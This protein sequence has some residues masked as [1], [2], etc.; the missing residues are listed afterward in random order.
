[1]ENSLVR[2]HVLNNT[3]GNYT[4]P[5]PYNQLENIPHVTALSIKRTR[6]SCLVPLLPSFRLLAVVV[7]SKMSY[8]S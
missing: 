4:T 6:I 7:A 1:M 8:E 5:S 2:E 3:C